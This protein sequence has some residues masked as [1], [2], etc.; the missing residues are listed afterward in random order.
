MKKFI[1]SSLMLSAASLTALAQDFSLVFNDMASS[2]D[3]SDIYITFSNQNNT[4]GVTYTDATTHQSTSPTHNSGDFLAS[5]VKLSDVQDGTFTFSGSSIAVYVSYGQGF[6]N[7]LNQP[8]FLTGG[9]SWDVQ[10]QNFEITRTGGSGDQGNMTNINYFTAPMA[11]RSYSSDYQS[12]TQPLQTVSYKYSTAQYATNLANSSTGTNTVYDG[13][14]NLVRYVGPSTYATGQI[15]YQNFNNYL[16]SVHSSG[17]TNQIWNNSAF[18]QIGESGTTGFNFNFQFQLTSTVDANGNIVLTGNIVVTKKNNATGVIVETDQLVASNAGLTLSG[19]DLDKITQLIYAQS[20]GQNPDIATWGAGWADLAT[21][22]A[23]NNVEASALETLQNQVVGEITT[24]ILLGFL[25]NEKN[26]NG[27]DLNTMKSYEW[28]QM[29]PLEAF[30]AIQSDPDFYNRWAAAVYDATDNGA[31][32]I[33][34][35]DRLGTGPLVDSVLHDGYD[36]DKWEI[37]IFDPVSAV[38][39]PRTVAF[40]AMGLALVIAGWVRRRRRD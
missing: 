31:Y 40:V 4:L 29:I 3:P 36:I 14:N 16:T 13:N 22:L 28:W 34:Y 5:S 37:D 24:A 17:V 35:S 15:P 6:S 21:Y 18:N 38:P 26:V 1:L 19:A 33:P 2:Y 10:Y 39:E 9:A 30:D 7:T 11:I 20:T 27:T 32:G 25:G 8:G 23:N 12:G